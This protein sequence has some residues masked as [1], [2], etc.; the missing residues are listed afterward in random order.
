MTP[1]P[2]YYET[3]YRSTKDCWDVFAR[4]T[5]FLPRRTVEPYHSGPHN[6]QR[7]QMVHRLVQPRAVVEIGFNLG[8]SAVMWLS[9]GV[10]KVTSME[11]QWTTKRQ[12]AVHLIQK[13]FPGRFQIHWAHSRAL[14]TLGG[15]HSLGEQP[16][17][18]FIDGSHEFD[19]V[20][21]DIAL[22]KALNTPFFLMDDYDSHH[23]PGVVQAVAETGLIPVAIFGT[24]AL[25][26]DG[27][28]F[29]KHSDPLGG[30]YYD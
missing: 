16:G 18:V 17:L 7:F 22:A 8:H 2:Y 30:N 13:E 19:W 10:E 11:I 20:R 21:S 27:K 23:G 12:E 6:Y 28:D 4:V 3:L 29:T 1:T 25:C 9:L 26:R 15:I 5:E 24:M 14:N